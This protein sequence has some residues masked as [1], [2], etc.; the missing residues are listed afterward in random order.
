MR[1]DLVKVSCVPIIEGLTIEALLKYAAGV[2]KLKHFVP[3]LK[4]WVHVDR[5]WLCDIIYTIDTAN[6]QKHIDECLKK[7][8]KSTE[9]KKN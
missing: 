4:D 3:N 9:V 5:K 1:R 7:R 8:R 6:F 2:E